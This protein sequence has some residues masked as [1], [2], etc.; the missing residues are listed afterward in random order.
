[1][2]PEA[3]KLEASMAAVVR[4]PK[5]TLGVWGVGSIACCCAVTARP[6][7]I[8]FSTLAAVHVCA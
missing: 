2:A 6:C 7:N 5:A 3:A 4:L 8:L 1:M